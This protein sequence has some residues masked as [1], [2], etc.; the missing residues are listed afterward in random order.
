MTHVVTESSI[1]CKYIDCVGVCP[2][3]C[4]R[5]GRP[6]AKA[7]HRCPMLT[8]GKTEQVSWCN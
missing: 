8:I 7:R 6:S 5:E 1:R 3:D 2:V 4:F